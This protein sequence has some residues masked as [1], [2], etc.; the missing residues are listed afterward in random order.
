MVRSRIASARLIAELAG[1]LLRRD[2]ARPMD[3]GG[4]PRDD[5]EVVKAR[6][7]RRDVLGEAIRQPGIEPIR[8]LKLEGKDDDRGIDHRVEAR[9]AGKAPEPGGHRGGRDVLAQEEDLDRLLDVL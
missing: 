9:A 4:G 1:G 6:Q 3:E 7:A 8:P 5:E 2:G